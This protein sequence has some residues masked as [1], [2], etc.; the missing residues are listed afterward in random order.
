MPYTH[1]LSG[2]QISIHTFFAEGDSN[3]Y[4]GVIYLIDISIH[5]F[6]AEGDLLAVDAEKQISISIHT[7]FAE[8]DLY[9]PEKKDLKKYFN[10]H[11]L[12][13]R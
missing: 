6:F 7:S 5:T 11:L 3:G 2:I 4:A 8:G 12:R 10:P 1:F 9:A 13:R